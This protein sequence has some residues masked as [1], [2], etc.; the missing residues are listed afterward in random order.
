MTS[1]YQTLTQEDRDHFL[2]KGHI[3]VRGCFDRSFAKEWT[4][5][6]FKRF[7]AKSMGRFVAN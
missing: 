7:G 3:V 2:E 6:A 4:D 5:L 1:A